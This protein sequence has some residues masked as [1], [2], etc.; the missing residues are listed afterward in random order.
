MN[1]KKKKPQNPFASRLGDFAAGL[2]T[3]G[4]KG[5]IVCREANL[6]SLTGFGCDNGRL[7]VT[8][9][10][11]AEFFT[12][13]R[14]IPAA[15]REAPWLSVRDISEFKAQ[16]LPF[17]RRGAYKLGF[18][19]SIP[20]SQYMNFSQAFKHADLSDVGEFLLMLRAVKTPAEIAAVAS[21]EALNDLIWQ[22]S[23]KKF[24]YGMTEKEMQ[25]IIRAWMNALG[26]GEAFETIVCA[27]ANGAECHHVPDGTVWREGEPLLVDMG[28]KLNGYCS[29]MTRCVKP[30]ESWKH[31]AQY[32]RVYDLVLKAN[33]AAI[34]AVRPG[35]S[36]SELDGIAR[37]IIS[38]AGY[39]KR[40]GH[41][42]GHGV[43]L[44]IHEQPVASSRSKTILEPGM[45]LTIEPGVY[46]EG[47]F[48]I[49][50]EDLVLVTNDGCEVLSSSP[51]R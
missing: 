13:F 21:A 22:K 31:A 20:T 37:G 18:E 27:G 32:G 38:K 8:P 19:D 41:S 7:V 24:R 10:G 47:K 36:C 48:G 34:E 26:D 3:C 1:K 5:A 50:I 11:A 16:N 42:L 33:L 45:I 15:K 4:I 25:R 39:G 9:D 6:K 40:F 14:Y 29:D 43:G 49:R 35:I 46:I 51:K 23:L 2:G 28:V 17:P 30:G 12:D 44:E